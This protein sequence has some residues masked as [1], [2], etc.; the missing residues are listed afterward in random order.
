MNEN[1]NIPWQ[2]LYKFSWL[3]YFMMVTVHFPFNNS[4]FLDLVMDNDNP[5][6]TVGA[7]QPESAQE[8]AVF[9]HYLFFYC[10][11]IIL[12]QVMFEICIHLEDIRE[13]LKHRTGM[14]SQHD[15]LK[16]TVMPRDTTHLIWMLAFN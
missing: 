2:Q 6:C 14:F 5:D 11:G 12:D 8:L 16:E 13:L 4:L 9:S 10:P 1:E 15:E 7:T 3:F